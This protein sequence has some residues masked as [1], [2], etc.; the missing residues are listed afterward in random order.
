MTGSPDNHFAAPPYD[1]VSEII[2]E[3]QTLENQASTKPSL[4]FL[5][6]NASRQKEALNAA[7]EETDF[8]SSKWIVPAN[9]MKAGKEHEVLL[10]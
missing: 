2:T 3:L 4:Q 6:L 10:I 7:W 8:K 5:S 1:D 9:R